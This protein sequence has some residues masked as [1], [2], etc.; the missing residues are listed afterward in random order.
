MCKK[1]IDLPNPTRP[2]PTRRVGSVFKAW[3]VVLGYNF[4]LRVGLG[5]G[6]KI[7][8]Q[9][10]R[11]DPPIFNIYLKYIIYLINFFI[12]KSPLGNFYIY[13]YIYLKNKNSCRAALPQFF[14]LILII[15]IYII[16]YN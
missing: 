13:I 1:P 11:P 16:L 5:L 12:K 6:H 9:Q 4:L 7:T 2:N 8:N 15:Y 14:L 10:T 3:W